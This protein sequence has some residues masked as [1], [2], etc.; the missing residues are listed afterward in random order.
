VLSAPEDTLVAE[1]TTVDVSLADDNVD[2]SL[3]G[4]STST[5]T[6]SSDDNSL[7]FDSTP[8]M[9]RVLNASGD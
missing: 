2:F 4:L 9:T 6:V 5:V 3:T 1:A 7:P 8:T